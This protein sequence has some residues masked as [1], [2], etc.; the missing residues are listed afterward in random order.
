MYSSLIL[1]D[2]PHGPYEFLDIDIESYS[3]SFL[4]PRL[5]NPVLNQLS[6]QFLGL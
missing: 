1:M 2:S 6:S 5:N 4:K 3:H